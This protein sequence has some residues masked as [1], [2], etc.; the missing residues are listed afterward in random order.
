MVR[1]V[2][3]TLDPGMIGA[4][5]VERAA[6]WIPAPCWAVVSL[7]ESGHLSVLAG[8]GLEPDL[9]AAA[10]GVAGWVRQHGAELASADVGRDGR[11]AG[12]TTATAVGWRLSA[13]T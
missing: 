12:G 4:L 9:G 6:T 2:N 7:D 1:A 5:L 13:G 11:V 8:R 10:R 3:T